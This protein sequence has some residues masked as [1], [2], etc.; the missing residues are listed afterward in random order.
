VLMVDLVHSNWNQLLAELA[1]WKQLYRGGNQ[2][3]CSTE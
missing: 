2:L 3:V 1:R